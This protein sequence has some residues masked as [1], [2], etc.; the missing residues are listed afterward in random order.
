[1]KKVFS[2][3]PVRAGSVEYYKVNASDWDWRDIYHRLLSF[4]WP[5]FAALVLGCYLVINLFFAWLFW[6]G[7]S[8]AIANMEAGSFSDAFFFSTETLATVGYGHLYPMSLYGHVVATGEI[9]VGMFGMAVITGLIFVRFARPA[10]SLLFSQKLVI[11]KFDGV[12]ML[13]LRVANQRNVPM[14]EARFRIMMIR[15]EATEE[16]EEIARF[17]ELR[18][19]VEGLI[20]FPAVLTIRHPIDEHSPLR[21]VTVRELERDHARFIASIVCTDP[22]VPAAVQ[23]RQHYTWREVHFGERFVEIYAESHEHGGWLVDYGRLNDTE[24]LPW[25]APGTT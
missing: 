12:P 25:P 15:T 10:A 14:V 1:M 11:S 16:G 6:I 13:M 2:P 22:V 21:G 7:G 24:P 20:E 3:T 23:S 5:C 18:L 8:G 17:H 19:E 9:L 4:S